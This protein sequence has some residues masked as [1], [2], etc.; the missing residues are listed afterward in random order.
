MKLME[1]EQKQPLAI[2]QRIQ[3]F[4]PY[5]DTSMTLS[6]ELWMSLDIAAFLKEIQLGF[7][8]KA[9]LFIGW[10]AFAGVVLGKAQDLQWI[11]WR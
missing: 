6:S 9:A 7:K 3:S 11:H 1:P 4:E 2:K 10:V 5:T 8:M